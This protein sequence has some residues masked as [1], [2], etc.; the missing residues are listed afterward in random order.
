MKLKHCA[1]CGEKIKAKDAIVISDRV[2]CKECSKTAMAM[3]CFK[4]M[5]QSLYGDDISLKWRRHK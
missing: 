5:E 1:I 4:S 3:A 2:I